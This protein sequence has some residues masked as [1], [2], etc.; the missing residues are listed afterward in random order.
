M[1]SLTRTITR[2]RAAAVLAGLLTVMATNAA[3]AH[4]ESNQGRY[5]QRIVSRQHGVPVRHYAAKR[6]YWRGYIAGKQNGFTAGY[7]AGK[8]HGQYNPKPIGCG[9]RRSR[10][11]RI[12]FAAGFADAY[13]RGYR[14]AQRKHQGGWRSRRWW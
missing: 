3:S 5:G 4:G 11:Y 7:E 6:E 9:K 12:G 2:W 8:C 13:A 1:N 10:S 14:L